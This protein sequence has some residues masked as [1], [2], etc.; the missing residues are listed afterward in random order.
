M[1]VGS[2]IKVS[3]PFLFSSPGKP[4]MLYRAGVPVCA[5]ECL[6]WR[7]QHLKASARLC[8]GAER[9]SKA[10]CGCT[11]ETHLPGWSDTVPWEA[12]ELKFATQAWAKWQHNGMRLREHSSLLPLLF[13]LLGRFFCQGFSWLAPCYYSDFSPNVAPLREA[14]PEHSIAVWGCAVCVSQNIVRGAKVWLLLCSSRIS[15]VECSEQLAE[16]LDIVSKLAT[17]QPHCL[18]LSS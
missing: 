6:C 17:S 11:R 7:L 2:C 12:F 3:D 4:Q 18:L 1:P 14:F 5:H 9:Q 10:W 13:L 15:Q 8:F 16:T